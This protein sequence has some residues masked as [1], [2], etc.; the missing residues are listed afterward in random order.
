MHVFP[1]EEQEI[2]LEDGLD[3]VFAKTL[4]DGAAV[5]VIDNAARLVKD[6]PSALPRQVS[7]VGV[8]QVEGPEQG[9]ETAQLEEFPAVERARAAS[10]VEARVQFSYGRVYPMPYSQA[11][12]LST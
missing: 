9:I 12:L 6:F 7:E 3:L 5:L 1:C 4:A 2:L 11:S 8:F 10:A